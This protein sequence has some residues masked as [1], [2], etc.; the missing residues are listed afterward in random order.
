MYPFSKWP[1][2]TS[3]IPSEEAKDGHY[4]HAQ[5]DPSTVGQYTGLKDKNGKR[6]FE[7]DIIKRFWMGAEIIY[8]V[9]YDAENA[10]FIGKALN[11]NGFTSFD[12]DGEM[13]EVIGNIND[14]PEMLKGGEG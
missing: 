14:N 1:V 7:G 2:K 6:I 11:K 4:E 3:I 12:G 10:H 13:F 9:R 8:C 5:V